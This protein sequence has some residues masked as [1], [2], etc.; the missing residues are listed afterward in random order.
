MKTLILTGW[1]WTEYAVAAAVALRAL[2]GEADVRGIS[3]RRLPE[4]LYSEGGNWKRIYLVGIGL[5]GDE[6]RLVEALKLHRKTEVVWISGIPMA[7]SHQQLMGRLLKA[8][9]HPSGLFNGAL[10]KAVGKAFGVDVAH[11]LPFAEEKGR[12]SKTVAVYRELVAAA[13]YAHRTCQ[14]DRAYETA[15]RYLAEGV[16]ESAWS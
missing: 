7:E 6:T 12:V 11:D 1:G 9:V 4:F 5:A 10:V 3:R 8:E 15:I 16:P 2:K 14:D 13:M